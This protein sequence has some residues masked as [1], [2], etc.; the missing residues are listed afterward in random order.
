MENVYSSFFHLRTE[1]HFGIWK[2]IL[3]ATADNKSVL[4]QRQL[5]CCH[6]TCRRNDPVQMGSAVTVCRKYCHQLVV[7]CVPTTAKSALCMYS[8]EANSSLQQIARQ[9]VHYSANDVYTMC[10]KAN[11][12][13]DISYTSRLCVLLLHS[14]G[15]L[16]PLHVY[17]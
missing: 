10:W 2:S 17:I 7:F 1:R 15:V 8:R 11:D 12:V 16:F 5:N 3:S 6:I 13:S 14:Y 9:K 4:N